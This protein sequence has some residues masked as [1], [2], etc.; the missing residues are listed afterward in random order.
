M[1]LP[2]SVDE[3]Y[4][5]SEITQKFRLGIPSMESDFT[6]RCVGLKILI[7]SVDVALQRNKSIFL[8]LADSVIRAMGSDFTDHGG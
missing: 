6:R 8:N 2:P 7:D 3:L 4:C 1:G 5:S